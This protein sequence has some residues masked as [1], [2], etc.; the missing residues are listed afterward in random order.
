[1]ALCVVSIWPLPF[2]HSFFL[3]FVQIVVLMCSL[4]KAVISAE[5]DENGFIVCLLF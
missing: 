5:I 4:N 3:P 1:M 2:I